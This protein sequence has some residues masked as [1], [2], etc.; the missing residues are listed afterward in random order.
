MTISSGFFNSVNHDRLYNSE[1]ISS[2]FDG[3][4]ND[5]VY[6]HVGSAF[7]VTPNADLN[8]SVIVGVGRAWFDHTWIFNDSAYSITLNPPNLVAPRYDALVF[9]IDRRDSVRKNTIMVVEGTPSGDPEYPTMIKEELHKQYPFAYVLLKP[10]DSKIISSENITYNVG[11]LD[12]PLVTGPLEVI[13]DENFFKQMNASFNSFKD[14]LDEEFTVWFDGIKEL[15]DDLNL[16]NINLTNSVDNVTIEY[17]AETKKLKVKDRAITRNKLSYDLQSII[18][19]LDP[20]SWSY[21]DYY[22]YTTSLSSTSE[23]ETFVKQYLTVSALQDWTSEQVIEYYKILKSDTSKNTLWSSA[24]LESY[25][26]LDFRDVLQTFG[27]GKY[28]SAIGKKFNVDMGDTYGIHKFI[29]IGINA[30]TREDGEKAFMTFQCEDAVAIQQFE[31][32][33]TTRTTPYSDTPINTFV[34]GLITHFPLE[35]Q[36]EIK[37]VVKKQMQGAGSSDYGVREHTFK[38]WIIAKDGVFDNYMATEWLQLEQLYDYWSKKNI[39]QYVDMTA[40]DLEEATTT[41]NPN[42]QLIKNYAG[43]PCNWMF[44]N[45]PDRHEIGSDGSLYAAVNSYGWTS[46]RTTLSSEDLRFKFGDSYAPDDGTNLGN[47]AG[48]VPCFCI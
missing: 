22:D 2:I 25:T 18:G 40:D 39:E 11:S 1:Q 46:Y 31:F 21:Q 41:R 34:E 47:K 3:V 6:E 15:I 24:P 28:S 29:L 45:P 14:E 23:E 26:I 30:D 9:D 20:S 48:I 7:S 4:I 8:D 36:S 35:L 38:L 5:G 44:R 27:S 16:G 12:C 19:V 37:T 17:P 10:G 42:T 13:N 33:G 32:S 43:S